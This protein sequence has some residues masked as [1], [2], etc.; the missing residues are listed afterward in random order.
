MQG[1]RFV[2][3]RELAARRAGRLAQHLVVV[4]N[5]GR[6]QSVARAEAEVRADQLID[7][8][9]EIFSLKLMA[10]LW[11][12]HVWKAAYIG[13]GTPSTAPTI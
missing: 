3:L 2:D 5:V 11:K 13:S 1:G 9:G 6:A 10:C 4:G 12:C 8:E 7:V